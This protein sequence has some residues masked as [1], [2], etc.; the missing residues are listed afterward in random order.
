ML[1]TLVDEAFNSKDWVFEVKWD[2]VR[3]ILFFNKVQRTIELQSRNGKFITHRYP[4]IVTALQI[5]S[6]SQS[7]IKCEKS[8]ILDG[9]IV[10]LDKKKEY[11]SFQNH[12]KR[13]NVDSTRDIEIL[14]RQLPVTYYLFDILYLDGK[15]LQTLPFLERRR[16][17]S[18]VVKVKHNF[19]ISDF[20]EERVKNFRYN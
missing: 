11:L 12:Q 9:E 10:V 4:E 2:G 5:T 16:I 14:S 18:E 1:A 19:K 8:V 20:I 17:L 7:D 13:M 6:S 15:N 3:S